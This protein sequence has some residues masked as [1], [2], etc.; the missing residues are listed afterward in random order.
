MKKALSFFLLFIFTI[1][2]HSCKKKISFD[3][4]DKL[5]SFISKTTKYDIT[6]KNENSVV[7]ILQNEDCICT[8]EDIALAK[9]ILISPL[10]RAYKFV[11]IVSSPRH[12][13]LKE[14]S[15]SDFKRIKLIVNDKDLLI[16]NGYISVTDKVIVYKNGIVNHFSDM[17][18]TKPKLIAQQLL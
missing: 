4:Q 9:S 12:K 7:L 18:I 10:Y 14:I 17:H 13:F 6:N 1:L 5:E 15:N 11:I 3:Y 2:F 16:S 8:A